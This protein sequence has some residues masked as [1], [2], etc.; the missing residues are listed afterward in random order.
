MGCNLWD[1]DGHFSHVLLKQHNC[2]YWLLHCQ[3]VAMMFFDCSLWIR[4]EVLFTDIHILLEKNRTSANVAKKQT[5]FF[6]YSFCP[7]PWLDLKTNSNTELTNGS[8]IWISS[9]F[10]TL[11]DKLN[12]WVTV[13]ISM[14]VFSGGHKVFCY[15]GQTWTTQWCDTKHEG[16]SS[17]HSLY[18]CVSM[19]ACPSSRIY[20]LSY[21][22]SLV[23]KILIWH[24]VQ[25]H[26]LHHI[27][28][29]S[30]KCCVS[31]EVQY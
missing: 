3:P 15:W 7:V 10:I 8:E 9:C 17:S 20:F 16:R 13:G 22:S 23:D 31:T 14:L 2:E 4:Q 5:G 27:F 19:N 30:T 18:S 11:T 1:W 29:V 6:C 21:F 25:N 26:V 12:L 24:K 28:E